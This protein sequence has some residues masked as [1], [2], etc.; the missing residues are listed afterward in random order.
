[1]GNTRPESSLA[2]LPGDMCG[3][4]SGS[5]YRGQRTGEKMDRKKQTQPQ[6]RRDSDGIV[7]GSVHGNQ[8]SAESATD[9]ARTSE[10]TPTN[11]TSELPIETR[12]VDTE[13]TVLAPRVLICEPEI[14]DRAL[15]ILESQE[16]PTARARFVPRECPNCQADRPSGTN[17][18]YVQH[19]AGRVRYC[20]CKFCGHTWTQAK[21]Q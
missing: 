2:V 16:T 17:Y 7:R 5:I 6:A 8:G 18:S 11:T 1:M 12:R 20:H 15:K 14:R 19:T 21:S 9:T 3:R 10:V 13:T 4:T